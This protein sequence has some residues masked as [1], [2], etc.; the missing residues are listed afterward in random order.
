MTNHQNLPNQHESDM[1]QDSESRKLILYNDD[2]NTF[3]H[4]I[5]SLIVE[6][7][8]ENHQAEQCAIIAHYKGKCDILSGTYNELQPIRILLLNKGLNITID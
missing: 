5:N 6:C 3:E 1:T 7:N 2:I 4:V 8:H